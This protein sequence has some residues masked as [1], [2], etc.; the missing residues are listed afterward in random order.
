[1]KPAGMERAGTALLA[2]EG[3]SDEAVGCVAKA[4]SIDPSIALA[5]N[6]LGMLFG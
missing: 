5:Y 3:P 1:M 2:A 4:V 6:T